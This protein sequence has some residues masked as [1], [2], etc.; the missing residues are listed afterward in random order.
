MKRTEAGIFLLFQILLLVSVTG[1]HAQLLGSHQ[2]VGCVCPPVTITL[3]PVSPPTLCA[4]TG[5]VTITAGVTGIGPL[6]YHWKENSVFIS[7]GGPYS[8]T[9]TASLVI[10]NPSGALNGKKYQCVIT[11]CSGS[12]VA[13]DNTAELSVHTLHGDINGDGNTDNIDFSLLNLVY[14][15]ACPNCP[16]DLVAD[17]LIDVKDFLLLLGEYNMSCR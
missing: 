10:T 2:H 17:G 13:T 16:E 11:N 8:G 3:Q 9:Q 15:T 6:T 5:N 12:S 4:G 7:D 1:S 14:N